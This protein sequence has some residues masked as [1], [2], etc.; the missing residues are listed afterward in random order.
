MRVCILVTLAL[1]GAA[2]AADTV[3]VTNGQLRSTLSASN[4]AVSR[5]WFGNGVIGNMA[6]FYAFKGDFTNANQQQ[7]SATAS[8]ALVNSKGPTENGLSVLPPYYLNW[9]Y[10]TGEAKKNGNNWDGAATAVLTSFRVFGYVTYT[11]A[12]N[13]GVYDQG[14]ET[15]LH[16]F[17]GTSLL[18]TPDI[19]VNEAKDGKPWYTL[20]THTGVD[21]KMRYVVSK[22]DINSQGEFNKAENAK[23]D[24]WF[25]P[26]YE[27]NDG[28]N[29]RIALVTSYAGLQA[30]VKG[31]GNA[32]SDEHRSGRGSLTFASGGVTSELTW[33][34]TASSLATDGTVTSVNLKSQ[35]LSLDQSAGFS[36]KA[37]TRVNGQT[38]NTETK[39]GVD[40]SANKFFQA[41]LLLFS[42]DAQKPTELYWD[43]SV[44]QS[45]NAYANAASLLVIL[46]AIAVS[47]F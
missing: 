15:S 36:I 46:A 20:V 38:L 33:S 43:P 22:Q 19:E 31:G 7:G 45:G 3:F 35:V 1:F 47:L 40:T 39:V 17:T 42:F 28:P 6:N 24:F 2:F 34:P 21:S 12:N 5:T 16:S 29:A 44:G 11:D 9:G 4:S 26:T 30:T 41:N 27:S 13:N 14:E 25:K 23:I 32:N 18:A 10:F 37:G 8:L